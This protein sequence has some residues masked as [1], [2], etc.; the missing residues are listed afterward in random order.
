MIS[1]PETANALDSETVD[2]LYD[3][4]CRASADGVRVLVIRGAGSIFSSGFDLRSLESETDATLAT[5]FLNVD[6]L[7][8]AIRR[9]P[10]IT[11]AV[12]VGS[13]VGAAADVVNACTLRIGVGECRLSFPGSA[14]GIALGTGA[15][16]RRIGVEHTLEALARRRWIKAADALDWG[17]LTHRVADEDSSDAIIGRL[18]DNIRALEPGVTNLIVEACT[19]QESPEC[20]DDTERLALSLL[21]GSIHQR[22]GAYASNGRSPSSPE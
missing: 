4:V 11:V 14:F 9:S 17:L 2:D 19:A 16:C 20:R 15:L 7:L 13:A 1:A 8:R 10:V 21:R 22:I 6:R 5:R 12:V 3:E 18:V